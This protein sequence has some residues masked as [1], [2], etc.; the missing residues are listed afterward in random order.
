MAKFLC[1]C[2]IAKMFYLFIHIWL[3]SL[4]LSS[5]SWCLHRPH[6]ILTHHSEWEIASFLPRPLRISLDT[7]GN[8]CVHQTKESLVLNISYSNDPFWPW[9]MQ[10]T[11]QTCIYMSI[12]HWSPCSDVENVVYFTQTSKGGGGG[13]GWWGS[14]TKNYSQHI[15]WTP[16]E[17]L[18]QCL[19]K[20]VINWWH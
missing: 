11:I 17:G 10:A 16:S 19:I 15:L 5:L 14:T 7:Q 20:W 2:C 3:S 18:Y 4:A 1:L 12:S 9:F 6:A 8:Q 13:M